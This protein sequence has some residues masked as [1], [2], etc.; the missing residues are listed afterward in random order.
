MMAQEKVTEQTAEMNGLDVQA[1]SD[2]IGAI[3]ADPSLAKF[4]FRARNTWVNGA[5]TAP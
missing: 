5:R 2:T 3:K 4:Q 1:A